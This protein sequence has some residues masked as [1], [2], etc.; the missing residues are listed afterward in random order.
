ML[1]TLYKFLLKYFLF[2]FLKKNDF[3]FFIL[4]KRLNKKLLFFKIVNLKFSFFL[5]NPVNRLI[6]IILFINLIFLNLI[7][8]NLL[9]KILHGL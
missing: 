3:F 6:F 5:N 4:L 1:L 2:L 8:L 9:K 7:F